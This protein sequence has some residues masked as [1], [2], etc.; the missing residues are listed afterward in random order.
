MKMKIGGGGGFKGFADLFGFFEISPDASLCISK[1]DNDV[2]AAPRGFD[3]NRVS[4][5]CRGG[6]NVRRNVR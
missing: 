2:R 3:Q 1:C 4:R 6:W 5:F